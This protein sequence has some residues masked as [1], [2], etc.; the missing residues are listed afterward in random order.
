MTNKAL[1]ISALPLLLLFPP[2]SLGAVE[3]A[4]QTL[5]ALLSFPGETL[6][7]GTGAEAGWLWQ[8]PLASPV[9]KS[10]PCSSRRVGIGS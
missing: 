5:S 8:Q 2:K 1:R 7:L 4:A 3:R 6:A 9:Q 10:L